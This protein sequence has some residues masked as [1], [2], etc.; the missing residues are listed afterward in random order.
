MS[1]FNPLNYIFHVRKRYLVAIMD[2]IT[3]ERD[4]KL[5]VRL[6]TPKENCHS[7]AHCKMHV[8]TTRLRIPDWVTR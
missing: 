3:S 8:P 2:N 7:D 6:F 5:S 1:L 4:R